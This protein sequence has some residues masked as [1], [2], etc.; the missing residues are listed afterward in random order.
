MDFKKAP[1]CKNGYISTAA[2]LIY[3]QKMKRES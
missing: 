2:Q 3:K 1:N